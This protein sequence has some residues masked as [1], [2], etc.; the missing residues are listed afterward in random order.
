MED[1][2]MFGFGVKQKGLMGG[3]LE[4]GADLTYMYNDISYNT[5]LN[6]AAQTNPATYTCASPQFYTCGDLPNIVSEMTQVKL[7][8]SYQVD[9]RSKVLVGYIY[10]MLN[11]ADY[12]YNGYQYGATPNSLMPTNQQSPSYSINLVTLAYQYIF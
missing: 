6:Y 1:D 5:T 10:Q 12:Y 7:T 2:V 9:K 11:A 4:L 8:G 3:K